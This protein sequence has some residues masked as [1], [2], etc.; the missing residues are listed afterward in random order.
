MANR[1][2]MALVQSILTLHGHGWSRRRIAR[3]LGV[4]R[5]TVGR[6]VD[7]SAAEVKP[8]TNGALG[9]TNPPRVGPES[10]DPASNAPL[11][12]GVAKP[13]SNAPT[14]SP[15]AALAWRSII[16]DKL[17]QGL[18]AQRI[19]QDLVADT[20]SP[21]ATTAC[22][23][24]PAAQR[25]HA[26]AVPADGVRAGEEAQVDFGSG[27]P[28]DHAGR[29]AAR[30]RGL[31]HRAVALP[32]GLQRSGV[33]ADDRDFLRCLENAFAHFGG[34]PQTLVIDNLK[35]AVKQ[36]DWFDP[37]LNPKVQ[38]FCRHYGTVILPTR[39]Y[40]PRHKGKVERGVGYVKDNA[41]KGR[42]FSFAG[43]A[44]PAPASTGR[45]GRRHAHPRHHAPAGGQGVRARSRSRRC[46]RC[47]STGSRSSTKRSG[48]STATA[49]SSRQGVL[50]GAAGVPGPRVCGRAGTAGWCGSSIRRWS[51]SPCTCSR[52][53]GA[54]A[55]C[56]HIGR[57]R[58]AAS[59][60]D[61]V[62]AGACRR[63]SART[64]GVGRSDAAGPRHRG[65]PGAAGTAEPGEQASRGARRSRP[66]DRARSY[67]AYRLRTRPQADRAT[68]RRPADQS[69][70]P[71]LDEHPI[72]RR[73]TT[74]GMDQG[75]SIT[76]TGLP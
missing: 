72:I 54:S 75:R 12:S 4:H 30:E 58:S 32:Q 48:T 76:N 2:K 16:T 71:F 52:S 7:Q 9:S 47:R 15:S 44:E 55:R 21:A 19:Y 73:W 26:A 14:G 40:T 24:S 35:A 46:C 25:R 23:G 59:N 3:E 60:G 50:L 57:R 13:A 8:A 38:S 33:A 69:M 27:A 1:L 6:H 68:A 43:R 49:T 20:A 36:A 5:E 37:E 31:P 66:A 41:L 42:T 45:A 28:V 67:G 63:G 70:L 10:S 65:G 39:P 22:G 53:R 18:S 74:T 62:A 11:G 64:H 51:R 56:E 17:D 34:V 29:Q 61:G